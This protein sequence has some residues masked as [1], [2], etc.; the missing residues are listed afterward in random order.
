M[1]QLKEARKFEFATVLKYLKRQ[2]R[3]RKGEFEI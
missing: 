1:E 2:G 3:E